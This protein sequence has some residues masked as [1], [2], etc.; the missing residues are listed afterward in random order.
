MTVAHRTHE[1]NDWQD[2]LIAYADGEATAAVAA[3]IEATPALRAAAAR[4]GRDSTRL[5]RALYRH[6]CPPAHDL[7]EYA[8][9]LLAVAPSQQIMA[10]LA[11]CPRCAAEARALGDFV[12]AEPVMGSEGV[13]APV[14]LR[15]ARTALRRIVAALV[16][17]PSGALASGLRGAG[18]AV[19]RTYRAGEF[20][21]TLDA[22][23]S[24]RGGAT[25]TG[26]VWSEAGDADTLTGGVAVLTAPDGAA[27]PTVVD[28][29]GNFTFNAL[30]PGTYRLEV[31]LGDDCIVVEG[32]GIER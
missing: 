30:A 32:I 2:E 27:T 9:G 31:T 8:L 29:W 14:P 22:G 13:S 11:R 24:E 28:D 21:L 18:D 1:H 25:L 4:Y 10:H 23:V 5:A 12:T 3:H 15:E 16:P 7:G 26:L 6:D 19:T 20:T 17:P